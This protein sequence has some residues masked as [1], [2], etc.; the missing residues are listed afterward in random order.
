MKETNRLIARFFPSKGF[1]IGLRHHQYPIPLNIT[2]DRMRRLNDFNHVNIDS[3]QHYKHL[4][5]KQPQFV[6]LAMRVID[7]RKMIADL[8]LQRSEFWYHKSFARWSRQADTVCKRFF[9]PHQIKTY[10]SHPTSMRRFDGS[11]TSDVVE[12]RDIASSFYHNLLIAAPLSR[13]SLIKRDYV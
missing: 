11:F 1:E 10:K 7:V 6:Y 13:N 3:R 5:Q 12:M 9:H 4:Q 8:Q 2:Q